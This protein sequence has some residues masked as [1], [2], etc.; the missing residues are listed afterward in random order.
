MR[1]AD[2]YPAA[3]PSRRLH[4]GLF[5]A[6]LLIETA[7]RVTPF[8]RPGAAMLRHF[9]LNALNLLLYGGFA[10]LA[11][12]IGS[13]SNAIPLACCIGCRFP[14]I[15]G[16]TGSAS[17][18]SRDYT[19]HR[20]S[21]RVPSLWRLHRVHH[22]DPGGRHDQPAH[23]SAGPLICCWLYMQAGLCLLGGSQW[24]LV[25]LRHRRVYCLTGSMPMSN[26]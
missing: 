18:R 13:G 11:A 10:W 5:Q 3:A 14:V 19:F 2:F 20:Q 7:A 22:T 12:R 1:L 21:I 24:L 8:R 23:P 6:L 25:L 16:A 15:S 9:A 4:F 17:A 26:S